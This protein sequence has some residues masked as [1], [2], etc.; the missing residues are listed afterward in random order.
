MLN[1]IIAAV[2]ALALTSSVLAQPVGI[3]GPGQVY[4]N[5][6]GSSAQ[7]TPVSPATARAPLLLNIDELSKPGDVNY[8][9]VPADR[10]VAHT[11]LSAARTDT[12]P[13]ANAVNPGQHLYIADIYAVVTAVNTLTLQRAGA[14]TINGGTTLVLNTARIAA[15]CVSDGISAWLCS[16]PTGVITFNGRSGAVVPI[17]SDFAPFTILEPGGRITLT[18]G[19]PVMTATVTAATTV[20]YTAYKHR[21]VPV[22]DGTNMSPQTICAVNTVGSCQLS[23]VLGANWTANSNWDWYIGVDAGTVRFCSG[24]AWTS[25]T[26]RGT[27]AGTTEQTRINGMP[28]NAVSMT[29]RYANASTFTCGVNQCTF[30]GSTRSGAAGQMNWVYAV[31]GAP[32][33]PALFNVWNMYNRVDVTSVFTDST[34]SW[35]YSTNTVRAINA[36]TTTARWSYLQGYAEDYIWADNRVGVQSAAAGI[37]YSGICHDNTTAFAGSFVSGPNSSIIGNTHGSFSTQTDLGFHF[38]ALCENASAGS[39]AHSFAGS[40]GGSL[41]TFLGRF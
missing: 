3:L 30:V 37:P 35:T 8:T 9:I 25:D 26:A 10:A 6:T 14:D 17:A 38:M 24:P 12:L 2:L 39:G 4:G 1:R 27:G 11:A 16:S 23:A 41:G 7:A 28:V 34:G 33:T 18:T 13:A 20:F 5:P 15:D 31:S 36:D 29:C 40:G 19:V 21:L 22:Y 32:P